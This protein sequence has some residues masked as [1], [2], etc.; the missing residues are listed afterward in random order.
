MKKY[1]IAKAL[2]PSIMVCVLFLTA[3][4]AG[5]FQATIARE[6]GGSNINIE[7]INAVR[8]VVF[9]WAEDWA[10]KN[11]HDY[12]AYYSPSF[13]SGKFDYQQWREKKAAVFQRPGTISLKILDLW[14]FVEGKTATASFI[15]KYQDAKHADIGEKVLKFVQAGNGWQIISEQW[16]PLKN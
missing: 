14:V 8:A 6:N 12:M 5:A 9:A 10:K 16:K 2:L 3:A 7:K 4:A 15:Q 11:I 13:R 1:M